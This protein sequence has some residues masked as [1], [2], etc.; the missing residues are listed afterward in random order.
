MAN[1]RS[2]K[3]PESA[4]LFESWILSDEWQAA[5]SEVSNTVLTHLNTLSGR[6]IF[7]S[8]G[9]QV[10]GFR[11]FMRDRAGVEWWRL[12]FESTL[13]PAVGGNPNSLY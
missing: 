6:E 7:R 5:L 11:E 4:K 1:F 3:C 12:Q 13:G 10:D 8:N 2:T 9:T